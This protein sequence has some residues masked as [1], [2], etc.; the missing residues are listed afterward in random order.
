[1]II[2]YAKEVQINI[3]RLHVEKLN[4]VA[5]KLYESFGYKI[6]KDQDNR[7]LMTKNIMK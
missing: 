7:F 4:V 6:Y 3:I 5:F 1:M 2:C